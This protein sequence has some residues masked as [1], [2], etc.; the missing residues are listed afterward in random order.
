MSAVEIVRGTTEAGNPRLRVVDGAGSLLAAAIHVNGHWEIF[1]YEPGPPNGPLA[2]YSEPDAR[3]WVA[4][5]GEQV[6]G[7]RR[8][9]TGS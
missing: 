9:V 4:W 8:S 7:A 5:I 2:A 1:S 3:E 6:L